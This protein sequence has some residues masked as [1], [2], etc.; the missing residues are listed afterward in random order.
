MSTEQIIKTIEDYN[1][2]IPKLPSIEGAYWR[3]LE[4][5]DEPLL[6]YVVNICDRI[7]LDVDPCGDCD[8][9]GVYQPEYYLSWGPNQFAVRYHDGKID[10]SALGN[11]IEHD[12]LLW[13][14][15]AL[16]LDP[17]KFW[18]LILF[19]KDWAED[20]TLNAREFNYS[21]GED[22]ERIVNK[23]NDCKFSNT[24]NLLSI[25]SQETCSV[26]ISVGKK[27]SLY[28]N[29][30]S[31]I[32]VLGELIKDYLSKVDSYSNLYI[33]LYA[34]AST[35]ECKSLAPNA[36]IASIATNLLKFLENCEID[37]SIKEYPVKIKGKTKFL[38]VPKNKL[39]LCSIVISLLTGDE[40]YDDSRGELL[41]NN[42]RS[43]K[44][45][46]EESQLGHS[47]YIN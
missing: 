41:K 43:A 44:R 35:G 20:E 32:Y 31:T 26:Q 36:R 16:K 3:G 25:E 23:I 9:N 42:L 46:L 8:E 24:N 30:P 29:N 13:M 14:L 1:Y 7:F 37:P 15:R 19:L 4:Y 11:Y 39:G 47:I 12:E 34:K 40:R 22:L 5:R 17:A 2:D 28:I 45:L 33:D 27:H 10:E 18:Y 38:P 6:E 21:I